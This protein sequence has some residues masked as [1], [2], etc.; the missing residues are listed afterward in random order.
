VARATALLTD[1]LGL[2]PCPPRTAAGAAGIAFANFP[3]SA[4]KS[5]RIP[6][7]P[8]AAQT[9]RELQPLEQGGV[10][11]VAAD[12]VEERVAFKLHKPRI[13]HLNRLAQC[14]EGAVGIA[15]LGVY[16]GILVAGRI[17]NGGAETTFAWTFMRLMDV[18]GSGR[19][20]CSPGLA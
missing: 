20:A 2:E 15:E 10:S 4:R 14:G 6:P 18:F 19:Y 12:R 11:R 17:A 16:L 8:F 9:S 13:A 1:D 5:R 7:R 3:Y